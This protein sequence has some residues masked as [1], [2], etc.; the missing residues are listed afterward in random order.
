MKVEAFLKEIAQ[1]GGPLEQA[2]KYLQGK[3]L[4][5]TTVC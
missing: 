2:F 4:P 5:P 3:V 1:P